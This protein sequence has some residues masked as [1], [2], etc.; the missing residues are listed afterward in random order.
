[1]RA[2]QHHRVAVALGEA[3]QRRVDRRQV[4]LGDRQHALHHAARSTCRSRPGRSRRGRPTRARLGARSRCST[5]ISPSVECPLARVSSPPPR[6]RAVAGRAR[7]SRAPRRRDEPELALRRRERRRGSRSQARVRP[8]SPSSS[9]ASSVAHRCAVDE[10]VGGVDPRSTPVSSRSACRTSSSVAPHGTIVARSGALDPALA[11][12]A[13]DQRRARPRRDRA[14]A[15]RSRPARA[16]RS[17]TAPR[18]SAAS[19]RSRRASSRRRWAGRRR[20]SRPVRRLEPRAAAREQV[21]PSRVR[22]GELAQVDRHERELDGRQVLVEVEHRARHLEQLRRL[23]RHDLDDPDAHRRGLDD[24]VDVLEAAL[25][26]RTRARAPDAP[27]APS[28]SRCRCRPTGRRRTRPRPAA[29]ITR[30]SLTADED[31]VAVR[32]ARPARPRA[33]R[34][35][36]PR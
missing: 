11:Q 13:L 17:R 4:A 30:T 31:H 5:R 29:A 21:V 14:A 18:G 7:R 34:R 22:G 2:A 3:E 10:R 25:R 19:A 8:R 6:G 23:R 24:E 28:A 12:A 27:P 36:P 16:A 33:R 1:M 26:R 35:G 9:R 20:G 32:R 15:G